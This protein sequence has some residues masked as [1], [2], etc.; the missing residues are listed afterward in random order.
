MLIWDEKFATGH[1]VIDDDHR[2][3]FDLVNHLYLALKHGFAARETNA[4]VDDLFEYAETHF[5]REEQLMDRVRCSVTG[6]NC[7]AHK[8]LR[9]KIA[10]WKLR[11]ESDGPSEM[12]L[13]DIHHHLSL[14]LIHHIQQLDCTLREHPTDEATPSAGPLPA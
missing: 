5:A 9:E 12:L 3:L 14:W 6:A 1:K 2:R 11:L 4:V 8:I 13:M 7:A 10:A